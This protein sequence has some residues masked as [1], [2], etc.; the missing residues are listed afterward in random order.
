VTATR[1]ESGGDC[2]RMGLLTD[3]KIACC[4]WF[5]RSVGSSLDLG[6]GEGL[7]S[8]RAINRPVPRTPLDWTPSVSRIASVIGLLSH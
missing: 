5:A 7:P 4:C 6:G 2:E 8:A 1:A 3:G